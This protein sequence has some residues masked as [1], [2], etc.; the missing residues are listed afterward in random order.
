M[1][2]SKLAQVS[3]SKEAFFKKLKSF[4][5]YLRAKANWEI[6][7]CRLLHSLRCKPTLLLIRLR[8][9]QRETHPQ[10]NNVT[11][12]YCSPCFSCFFWRLLKY[13][14]L[15]QEQ[16]TRGRCQFFRTVCFC[17]WWHLSLLKNI[18]WTSWMFNLS[19]AC[20]I[21]VKELFSWRCLGVVNQSADAIKSAGKMRCL[22]VHAH[23]SHV[24]KNINH[25]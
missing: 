16:L 6:V 24:I 17:N 20:K 12:L 1:W 18:M 9:S 7:T 11:Y 13:L 14:L 5:N 2:F 10:S 25:I 4:C 21:L 22:I 15:Q 19:P 8:H 3:Q 23:E